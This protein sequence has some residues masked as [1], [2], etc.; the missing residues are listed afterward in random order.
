MLTEY[1]IYIVVIVLIVVDAT[2]Y[3][4]YHE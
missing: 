1:Y 4:Y 2:L 3:T